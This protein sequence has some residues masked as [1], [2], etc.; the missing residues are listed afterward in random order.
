M[1]NKA[2][3]VILLRIKEFF[4]KNI[5]KTHIAN[6]VKCNSIKKFNINPFL[7]QYLATG[8][9]GKDTAERVAK[10]L[11]YPR[12]FGTSINTTFGTNVQ[13]LCTSIFPEL[14]GSV[15]SGMDIE[16]IDCTDKRKK[17][18]QLKAGPNTINY[19]DVD[20]IF[21]KFESVYRLSKANHLKIIRE[22]LIVGILYGEAQ[23]LSQHY[24]RINKKY[25]VYIGQ[26]F[27]YRITGDKEFYK[28]IINAI[29]EVSL[30]K[31]IMTALNETI[32]KL[33]EDIR[34]N[35]YF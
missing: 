8:F 34:N 27:W 23:D 13:K 32:Q 10:A 33:A 29:K 26:E 19:D 30:N 31:N 9:E 21:N 22:D 20:T 18:C 2:K 7:L 6:I 35:H 5:I 28:D 4:E 25:P 16:F 1:E 15:I 3:Q 24:Q 11:I 14:S 12:A 17:Y